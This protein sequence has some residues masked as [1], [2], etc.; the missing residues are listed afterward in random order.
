MDS[1][2]L[3]TRALD[4]FEKRA[5]EKV[6]I[7]YSTLICNFRES[8]KGVLESAI[9][10]TENLEHSLRLEI[11]EIKN[12]IAIHNIDVSTYKFELK[13]D[14]SLLPITVNDSSEISPLIS[15]NGWVNKI[16]KRAQP[17]S[18]QLIQ[19]K[20]IKTSARQSQDDHKRVCNEDGGTKQD[21]NQI[22][23]IIGGTR[24]NEE[25]Y[26]MR[27]DGYPVTSEVNSQL[28]QMSH[29]DAGET[30]P[31]MSRNEEIP[32]VSFE[33]AK[34]TF[35]SSNKEQ[36]GIHFRAKHTEGIKLRCEPC[37]VEFGKRVQ[38]QKHKKENHARM[39]PCTEKQFDVDRVLDREIRN[40]KVFY[41]VSWKGYD[42]TESTWE[43]RSSLITDVP[44][45]VKQVETAQKL[46]TAWR[47]YCI[48]K[49]F[50]DG[51][52][53]MNCDDCYE[54][55]H[56]SCLGIDP[57]DIDSSERWYCLNCDPCEDVYL[58]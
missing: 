16:S 51:S 45:L 28:Q 29:G 4:E 12:E 41:R 53:M 52:V 56:P 50:D 30:I 6:T 7:G 22:L 23:E 11:A 48:C 43:P 3:L 31:R 33:C 25:R 24:T 27:V 36:L 21:L 42:I 32:Y 49:G 55:F 17:E 14:Q 20:A 2:L 15:P 58:I 34:C 35:R 19:N 37:G 9:S 44:Y 13:D 26:E 39:K 10:N 18:N 1:E 54:W 38:L 47:K 57:K 8:L 5:T 46:D 40:G